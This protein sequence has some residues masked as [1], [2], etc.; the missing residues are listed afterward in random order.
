MLL[1]LM[2]PSSGTIKVFEKNIT[3]ERIQILA[4]IGSLV[5]NPSYYPH[6]TAYENLEALR[7]ILGVPKTRIDEVLEIVRLKEAAHK[8]VKGFSLGMKQRLGIAASLL[9]SPELLILD[10]PTNGLDP[11][12]IIEIRNLIKRL[13]EEYGMT[14]IIST[15][16]Y[17]RLIKWQHKLGLFRKGN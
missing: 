9:H 6:L 10:E 4:K 12:G 1:G 13:P 7:K 14:I 5:E 2:K 17:Q 15:I 3:K 8:K 16:Y 11:S